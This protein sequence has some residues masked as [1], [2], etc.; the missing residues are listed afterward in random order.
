V[1]QLYSHR[2]RGCLLGGDSL[3]CFTDTHPRFHGLFAIS[4][5]YLLQEINAGLSEKTFIV[6]LESQRESHDIGC[7]VTKHTEAPSQFTRKLLKHNEGHFVSPD[8][9]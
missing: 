4:L 5:R 9:K 2:K 6:A 7:L 3:P 1:P 8:L